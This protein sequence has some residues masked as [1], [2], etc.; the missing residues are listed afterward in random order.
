[1]QQLDYNLDYLKVK[2]IISYIMYLNMKFI[3]EIDRTI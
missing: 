1:M 3:V 2:N